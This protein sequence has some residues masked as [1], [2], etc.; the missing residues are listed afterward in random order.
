[1]GN[2]CRAF[3]GSGLPSERA[4]MRTNSEAISLWKL[5]TVSCSGLWNV[6]ELSAEDSGQQ[7]AAGQQI[8]G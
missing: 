6:N 3:C 2:G 7:T 1:M 8:Y 4:V 5:R